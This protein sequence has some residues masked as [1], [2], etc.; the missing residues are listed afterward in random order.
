MRFKGS[1]DSEGNTDVLKLIAITLMI[2]DH[3]GYLFFPNILLFRIVGRVGFPVFAYLIA[4][5][6]NRTSSYEKYLKRLLIFAFVTVLPYQYFSDGFNAL[7]TLVFGLISIH[8]FKKKD[9]AIPLGLI[10][11]AQALGT[12]Y[13]WFGVTMILIFNIF[14]DN[15]N[16][17]IMS[18]ILLVLAHVITTNNTIHLYS[19]FSLIVLRIDFEN[20]KLRLPKYTF[21]WFYPV[22]IT[23][24]LIIKGLI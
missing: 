15:P 2:I 9:Y 6:Y 18:F 3:L 22:H 13:G 11:L 10:I 8:H 24:F 23:L 20:V 4:L 19:L 12:S 7:F 5:G 14:M 17:F 21:Y 16:K 1:F